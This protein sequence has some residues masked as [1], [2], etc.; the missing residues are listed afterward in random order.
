MKSFCSNLIAVLLTLG[1]SANAVFAADKPVD[2]NKEQADIRKMR[3]EALA[4]IYKQKPELKA[5]V[6]AA[7][8]YAVFTDYGVTLFFVGGGGG[9][10][11]AVNNK[12]KK[13][14]FM[15]MGQASVGLGLG[16]KE[17]RLLLVFKSQKAFDYFIDKGW[18]F[19]GGGTVAAAAGGKGASDTAGSDFS[20]EVEKYGVAKNGLMFETTLS[21]TKYW[22][23]K[24]LN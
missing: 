17:V 23:S 19:G 7:P 21:G 1:F 20:N 13:E 3:T 22:K 9:S 16:A 24:E 5:K 2:K 4:A 12:T 14:T 15:S 6:E 18:E 11:I 10:G 8:G